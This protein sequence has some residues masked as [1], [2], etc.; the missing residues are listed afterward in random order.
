MQA[1]VIDP[2]P[3]EMDEA[4]RLG[5]E[6]IAGF[7]EDWDPGGRQFDV[8]ALCQTVDHLLDVSATLAAIRRVIRPDGLFFV[9]LVDFRAAY[10]RSWSVEDAIKIDHPYYFV[11]DTLEAYLARIGFDVLRRDFAADHLHISYVCRPASADP[12]R[13]PDPTAVAALLREVRYVQ[14]AP[15]GRADGGAP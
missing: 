8:V 14:N 15:R 5:L 1:T 7:V 4:R 13:L 12:S 2:S 11:S 6:T 3:L 10:L 9:D